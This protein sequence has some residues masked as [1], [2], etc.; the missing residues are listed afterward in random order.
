MTRLLDYLYRG[1]ALLVFQ[2]ISNL[3]TGELAEE[4]S[5]SQ[6]L[7]S[8]ICSNATVNFSTT[9]PANLFTSWSVFVTRDHEMSL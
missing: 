4:N 9:T 6:F 3:F 2:Y 1:I 7:E 5:E 8:S